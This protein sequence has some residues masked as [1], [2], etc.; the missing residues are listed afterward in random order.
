MVQSMGGS[1]SRGDKGKIAPRKRFEA[2]TVSV[3]GRGNQRIGSGGGVKKEC[4]RCSDKG[5]VLDRITA[6]CTFGVASVVEWF[7]GG[8]EADKL[9]RLPCPKCEGLREKT[10]NKENEYESF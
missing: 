3:C 1:G 4:P 8:H 10:T 7:F 9:D 5:L 2:K 6:F